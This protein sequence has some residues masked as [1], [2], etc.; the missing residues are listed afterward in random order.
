MSNICKICGASLRPGYSNCVY[1]GTPIE[2][3]PVSAPPAQSPA[4]QPSYNNSFVPSSG[5]VP[6]SPWGYPTSQSKSS[7]VDQVFADRNWKNNW[8]QAKKDSEKLGILLTNTDKLRD[9]SRFDRALKDYLAKKATEN[10]KYY[11]LDLSNQ[12]VHKRL[13]YDIDDVVELIRK[14]YDVAVPDY[15]M[16]VGDHSVIP[17]IK[18]KAVPGVGDKFIP[19]DLPYITL[20]T[21]SP[22]DGTEYSFDNLTQVGRVPTCAETN[23][24]EAVVYFDNTAAFK[25]YQ[26]TTSF[27][28]SSLSWVKTSINEFKALNPVMITSPEHTSDLATSR[29]PG[30]VL[31]KGIEDRYNF[32]CFDVHGA[33]TTQTWYGDINDRA[34]KAFESG[35]LPKN[36]QGY[37]LCSVACYGAKPNIRPGKTPSI[38][39]DALA[40]KCIA[41]VG[42]TMSAW[43]GVD[44]Y[45]SCANILM[46]RFTE[47]VP[48]GMTVGK[49]FLES[50]DALYEG[51]VNEKT[52]KTVA[53][54]ALYGD[55][56][57]R[58]VEV[59]TM[60]TF[61]TFGGLGISRPRKN[62]NKAF[63][64]V[65]FDGDGDGATIRNFSTSEYNRMQNIANAIR[66]RGN[67]YVMSN[68]STMSGVEPQ[69]YKV[70]GREG[71]RAVYSRSSGDLDIMVCV[72]TDDNG[73]IQETFVSK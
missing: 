41:F 26:K 63:N 13:N 32:L 20:D 45:M 23:F 34:F 42:S 9:R 11:V 29:M 4:A 55:P 67:N 31:F 65:S 3:E 35:L 60:K 69:I 5:Y 33:E 10:I 44:G 50:L 2:A 28:Y 58:L 24:E 43:G 40:K 19:S 72:H 66:N 48:K 73:N 21:D 16:I 56:S 38:L 1:C 17:C 37:V 52:I 6:S 14:V 61:S 46:A 47:C 27:A 53:E 68:F 59:S 30:F 15:L 7:S 70:V 54:F 62:P 36:T 22:W 71:Y 25:P 64:I 8:I 49:A 18:W 57:V 39:V 12:S 51:N